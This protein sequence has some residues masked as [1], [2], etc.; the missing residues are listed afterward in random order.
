MAATLTGLLPSIMEAW[1][2]LWTQAMA[3]WAAAIRAA[4]TMS[5]LSWLYKL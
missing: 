4:T 5:V 1:L 2:G 3:M